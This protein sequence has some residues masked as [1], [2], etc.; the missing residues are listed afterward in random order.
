MIVS[1]MDGTD[2][3]EAFDCGGRRRCASQDQMRAIN[4]WM[5]GRHQLEDTNEDAPGQT[6]I[7]QAVPM[8]D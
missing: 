6:I 5:V 2:G 8:A 4:G 1:R 3:L 7:I